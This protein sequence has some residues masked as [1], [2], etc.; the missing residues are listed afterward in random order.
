MVRVDRDYLVVG[1]G[2]RIVVIFKLLVRRHTI[3]L[4]ILKYDGDIGTINSVW[5][6]LETRDKGTELD[7]LYDS[8]RVRTAGDISPVK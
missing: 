8:L 7:V 2:S 4:G 3:I 1:H 5:M 6:D